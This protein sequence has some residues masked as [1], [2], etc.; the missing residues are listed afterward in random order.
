VRMRFTII[1]LMLMSISIFIHAQDEESMIPDMRGEQNA[2][3]FVYADCPFYVLPPEVEG[4]T[5]ECGYLFVPENR[6]DEDSAII[7]IAVMWIYSTS[8]EPYDE[9]VI[10]LEGGPGGASITGYEHWY[11]SALREDYN[12]ILVDQRGAGFSLPSL[13][14]YESDEQDD[15]VGDC[16]ERLRDEGVDLDAYNSWENAADI[17]DL[18]DALEL[19]VVNLFGTSYGSRLAL[20]VM[21]DYPE[22]IRSVII[23]GVYPPNVNAY[24]EQAVN[25]WGALQNMFAACENDDYCAENYPDLENIFFAAMESLND[26]PVEIEVESG[27]IVDMDGSTFA[28][29]IFQKM[30]SA[31]W[32]PYIP[33]LIYA[34]A[35]GDGDAYSSIGFE[36]E[37]GEFIEGYDEALDEAY[38]DYLEFEDYDEMYDYIEGL[39]EEEYFA[40]EEAI[41]GVIDDDSEGMFTSVECVEE[42]PFNSV[43]AYDELSQDVPEELTAYMAISVESTFADC[44]AW[45]VETADGIENEVVE[46]DIPTLVLSG[47]L[48]PI[49]PPVWGDVAA[50][51]LSNSFVYSYPAIGHGAVDSHDCPTAMALEFLDNPDFA[52]DDSCI[53]DMAIEFE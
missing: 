32:L 51:G 43:D 50:E 16:A 40:I 25:F 23:E 8:D 53:G 33:A 13:N 44:D 4:E 38:M 18:I 37:E 39:D 9:P 19:D 45:D 26:S 15:F 47:D 2:G 10:Y 1:V 14:C 52:P 22:K 35:D 30:Y 12:I 17:A 29:D 28:D 36:A 34:A 49:T 46:S 24:D 41:L 6:N 7:Q 27:E 31:E 5:V 11:E 21:R 42:I 3:D 48:D 20:T